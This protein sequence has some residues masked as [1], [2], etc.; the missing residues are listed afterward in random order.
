MTRSKR[1]AARD[2]KIAPSATHPR[3]ALKAASVHALPPLTRTAAI[4]GVLMLV[5]SVFLAYMPVMHAGYIR[6]DDSDYIEENHLL[7]TAAGLRQ[8]WTGPQ[9]YPP[10]VPYYPVTYT[11]HWAEFHLWG[12]NPLGYHLTNVGLHALNALLVWLLLR[13]LHVPGA[14]FGALLFALHPVQVQSVAWLA[15]RKNVLSALFYFLTVLAWLRFARTGSWPMY[16]LALVVF[17]LGLLSKTVICTL[18][19]ALLLWI[20]WRRPSPMGKH[21]LLLA[22]LLCLAALGTWLVIWRENTLLEGK[23]FESRFLL[24]ERLLIAGRA[25]WFYAG[26]LLMPVDLVPIYP[27]WT[28]DTQAVV[29]YVFPL[30][31]AMVIVAAWLLRR[32][33]GRAPLVA[34]LFFAVTLAPTSGLVDFGYMG[35]SFVG[36]HYQYIPSLAV[37]AGLAAVGAKLA[38]RRV[39]PS[40]YGVPAMA[41]AIVLGVG[42]LTWRQCGVYRDAETFWG[43]V[44]AHNPSPTALSSLGEAYLLNRD[45]TRA[46]DL[47]RRALAQSE[48]TNMRFRLGCV[49]IERREFAA[50]AEQFERA[51]YLNRTR[52]RLRGVNARA[53]FNL[54]YCRYSLGD[55]AQAADACRQ[56]VELD[57]SLTAAKQLQ[58]SAEDI[59]RNRSTSSKP[60]AQPP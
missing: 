39:R 18:P 23:T 26:K 44:V 16:A 37:F 32:R 2:H 20:W 1:R 56:A 17:V 49:L 3:P 7:R 19:V 36:D 28:V 50:A 42:A 48:H 41:A 60:A 38:A 6:F 11:S 10:G 12:A 54:G 52:N 25:L 34:V 46:E 53:L 14:L 22:P 24:V 31:A 57:P 21:L 4:A 47:L 58:T 45:F 27:H 15:E 29:P 51:L 33:I 59:L 9:A 8:I 40:Y 30:A 55:Y 43:Y 13:R 35:K 5:G